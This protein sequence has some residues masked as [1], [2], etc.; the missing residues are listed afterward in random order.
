LV[1]IESMQHPSLFSKLAFFTLIQTFFISTISGSLWSSIEGEYLSS[2]PWNQC[3]V[4]SHCLMHFYCAFPCTHL[5]LFMLV[6]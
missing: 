3:R 2:A 6:Q 1:E 5:F 4:I